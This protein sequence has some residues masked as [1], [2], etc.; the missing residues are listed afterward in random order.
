MRNIDVF[1]TILSKLNINHN[2]EGRNLFPVSNKEKAEIK[3]LL[4]F[5]END[6]SLFS[7]NQRRYIKGIKGKWRIAQ[8]NQWKLIFI[9]DPKENIYE[10]YDIK[11]DP[12]ETKNLA[13]NTLYDKEIKY[14]KQEL[15][16]WIKKEDMQNAEELSRTRIN[17]HLKERLQSL[18][19]F[20]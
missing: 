9:P 14:L 15:F 13:N 16:Q 18:G 1:P 10:F 3:S 17:P 11:N 20:Q 5:G 6:Y 19:Y 4:A 7:N 8:S 12:L 2:C